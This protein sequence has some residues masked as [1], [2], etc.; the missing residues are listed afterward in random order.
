LNYRPPA[1]AA[2][3][4][5]AHVQQNNPKITSPLPRVNTRAS[6]TPDGKRE[7]QDKKK[8]HTHTTQQQQQQQPDLKLLCTS[9]ELISP[10]VQ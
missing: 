10:E 5:P 6:I 1:A 3:A 2:A 7:A 9:H 8:T 4:T